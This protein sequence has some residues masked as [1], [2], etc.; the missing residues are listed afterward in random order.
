MVSRRKV[1][2]VIGIVSI[3]FLAM[4]L[5]FFI[6]N[7]VLWIQSIFAPMTDPMFPLG[8]GIVTIVTGELV[9]IQSSLPFTVI[10]LS[11]LITSVIWYTRNCRR[12]P[13]TGPILA[14][15]PLFFAWRSL[16][17]YFFYTNIIALAGILANEY[18]NNKVGPKISRVS[19]SGND[20]IHTE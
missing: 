1:I 14:I 16:W 17:P 8:V 15:L 10:E 2:P 9:N 19:H 3:L 6:G 18:G 7:P 20:L 12:Y 13:N 4:N 11:A 5:P